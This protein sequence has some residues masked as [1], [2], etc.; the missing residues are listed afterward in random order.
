MRASS[1]DPGRFE[2]V[3]IGDERYADGDELSP[4]PIHA[5]RLLGARFV[6]AVDVSAHAQTT[7]PGVPQAWIDKDTRRAR[8]VL[9][10]APGADVLLHPDIGYY[11]GTSEEYRR[12]VIAVAE[13]YTRERIPAIRA[14]LGA[15]GLEPPSLRRP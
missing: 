6:I 5:A 15:A 13:S 2:P 11:A 14:A 4:V 10:E 12:R 3:R 7:P 8:Q 9:A 1:A